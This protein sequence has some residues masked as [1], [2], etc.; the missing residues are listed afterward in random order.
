MSRTPTCQCRLRYVLGN[1]EDEDLHARVH[2]DY[3]HGPKIPRIASLSPIAH[4][5]DL[6]VL[7]ID[8]GVPLDLRMEAARVAYVAC[9][10]SPGFKAGYDGTITTDNPRLYVAM[11][12]KH[13]VAMVLVA[14]TAR[15]WLLRWQDLGKA[16]LR[17]ESAD[18]GRRPK[19]GR[20]WV[21]ASRRRQ[22]I[23]KRMLDVVADDSS[24]P[25]SETCWQLPFSPAGTGLVQCLVPGDW[26]GDGDLMDLEDILV[27]PMDCLCRD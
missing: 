6:N 18:G 4:V 23:A 10:E 26:F 19:V 5:D 16:C 3:L 1:A 27:D 20:L 17:S 9:R 21:A 8:A 25:L 7:R 14:N 13:A 22:G 15:S 11:G 12:G 2:D 24:Q